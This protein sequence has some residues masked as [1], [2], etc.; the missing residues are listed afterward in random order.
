MQIKSIDIV[1]VKFIDIVTFCGVDMG[2]VMGLCGQRNVVF[3]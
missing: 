1:N 3:L 2:D